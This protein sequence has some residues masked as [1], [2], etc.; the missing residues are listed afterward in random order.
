M[1]KNMSS[2]KQY[3]PFLPFLCL[4]KILGNFNH[5]IKHCRVYLDHCMISYGIADNLYEQNGNKNLKY[6]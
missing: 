3:C 5:I 1:E 4:N 6:I 2:L